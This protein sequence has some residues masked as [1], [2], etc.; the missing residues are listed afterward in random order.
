MEERLG[1]EERRRINQCYKREINKDDIKKNRGKSQSKFPRCPPF[2]T[3]TKNELIHILKAL[4]SSPPTV[5][6]LWINWMV[7]PGSKSNYFHI[8]LV[9]AFSL[10]SVRGISSTA[11]FQLAYSFSRLSCQWHIYFFLLVESLFYYIFYALFVL[12]WC[13]CCCWC[14]FYYYNSYF[15]C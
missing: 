9:L 10:T 14:Y 8:F 1:R 5:F 13:Q 15:Y 3:P 4:T 2:Q 11:Q 6:K 12:F 7:S